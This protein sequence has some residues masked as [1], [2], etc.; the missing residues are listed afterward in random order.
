MRRGERRASA[1]QSRRG[2]LRRISRVIAFAL[3]CHSSDA[4]AQ[5]G[6]EPGANF[7]LGTAER[8]EARLRFDR[9][10]E[11]YNAGDYLGALAEFQRAHRLTGHPLVLYNVALVEA[12]LGRAAEAVAALEQLRN[13]SSQLGPERAARVEQA[14][15]EQLLRVATLSVVPSVAGA[16]LQ[17]DNVDV[18]R[19]TAAVRLSAGPHLISL[20]AP[21]YEPRH[22]SLLLAAGASEVV[23]VEMVPLQSPLA[24]L[25]VS[26]NVPDVEIRERD[27]LLGKTPLGSALVLGAGHHELV[28]T[29]PG[30]LPVRRSV[31][32]SAGGAARL[33]ANLQ[34]GSEPSSRAAK[35]ELAVSEPNAIVLIDGEARL[36]GSEALALPSGRHEL[37][38]ARAGFFDVTRPISLGAGTTRLQ[39]RL[40]PTPAYLSDYV[41]RAERQ[42]TW[43][44]ITASAGLALAATGGAFLLWNQSKKTEAKERFEAYRADAEAATVGSCALQCEQTL[45]FLA[46]DLDAKRKR[47]AYG[48]AGV[49]I[50]AA[51]LGAGALLWAL[52]DDP[53]RYQRTAA[54]ESLALRPLFGVGVGGL[55]LSGAF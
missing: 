36:L 9:G 31:D 14:Y 44:V 21:G 23:R 55:R 4:W 11:L 51:A 6:S 7:A 2:A 25:D 40:I 5:S 32:L 15:R 26:C 19:G 17:I 29:R 49:G 42:R 10:L 22:L 34:L 38:V 37:R 54:G 43:A 18:P 12:R 52:A 8:A 20:S 27:E 46:K 48:W 41:A 53:R 28:L 24:R 3:A 50:G 47:D 16:A 30:Y 35:L 45:L 13:V 39:I 33:N 1:L